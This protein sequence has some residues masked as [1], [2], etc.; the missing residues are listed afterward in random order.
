MIA[1]VLSAGLLAGLIAGL[2]VAAIQ[3]FSTT[4]LILKAET[5]EAAKSAIAPHIAPGD[6]GH[7]H[8]HGDQA[9]HAG[10]NAWKPQGGLERTA[11]TTLVTIATASAFALLVL[12]AM[13]AS[14]DRIGPL[15]AAAFGLA[16]FL[17]FGLAPAAGL[18]PE[19]PGAASAD[20]PDRQIWWLGTALATAAGLWLIVRQGGILAVAAGLAL[21]LLPHLIGA[22]H[23]A[24]QASK[25]PAE[26]AARFAA[27]S[28]VIQALTWIGAASAAGLVWQWLDRRAA[29][30]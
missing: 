6:A 14:G 8:A 27:L 7:G 16:G 23:V 19:L 22:P 21:I 10:D 28:L 11:F 17:A 4:P 15:A 9:G 2:L 29:S 30:A 24:E 12:A 13:L 1:R 5:F 18:P 3:H 26:L 20:L 25:V